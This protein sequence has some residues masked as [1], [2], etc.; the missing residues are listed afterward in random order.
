MCLQCI[1]DELLLWQSCN[2][3]SVTMFRAVLIIGLIFVHSFC[4]VPF[5]SLATVS[6]Q[7]AAWLKKTFLSPV[8]C[9][10]RRHR[11]CAIVFFSGLMY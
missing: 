11:E 10:G 5:H 7:L 1:G 2:F 6:L 8:T 4:T 3:K 9:P